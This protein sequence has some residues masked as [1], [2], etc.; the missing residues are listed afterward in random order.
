ML[1]YLI[2]L[3][4]RF[5]LNYFPNIVDSIVSIDIEPFLNSHNID[6]AQSLSRKLLE[7]AES[8]GKKIHITKYNS[9]LLNNIEFSKIIQQMPHVTYDIP[10]DKM[11]DLLL[12]SV[13]KSSDKSYIKIFF[14]MVTTHIDKYD[15][16]NMITTEYVREVDLYHH[17]YS[18]KEFYD[19]SI[20]EWIKSLTDEYVQHRTDRNLYRIPLI[21]RAGVRVMETVGVVMSTPF[22]LLCETL[23]YFHTKN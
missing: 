6:I 1:E 16:D 12:R 17:I 9:C 15:A 10:F 21:V 19:E 22:R 8:N 18:I 3:N 20:E 4:K 23:N 5:G 13:Q 7:Y 2:D 11:I 14:D